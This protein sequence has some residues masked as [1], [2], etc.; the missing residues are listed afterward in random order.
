MARV[1]RRNVGRIWNVSASASS[2][3]ASAEKV[4]SPF[5]ISAAQLAVLARDRVE[6]AAGVAHDAAQ[7]HL[8]LVQRP[9]QVGAVLEERRRVAERVV[10]VGRELLGRDDPGLVQPLL[11]VAARARVE[12]PEDLVQ[13][14]RVL[15]V[16]VRAACRRRR[17]RRPLASPGVSST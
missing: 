3:D 4:A 7:R 17:G 5:V 2:R 16:G 10:Q 13:L 6:H 12:G 8:L 11:E 14:D 9:Q 1:S 15:H